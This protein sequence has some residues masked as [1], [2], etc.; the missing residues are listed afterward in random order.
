MKFRLSVLCA[1]ALLSASAAFAQSEAF[2]FVRID[3]NPRTAAMAGAGSA[4]VRDIAYAS[5]R[6][7]AVIPF[8][9]GTVD[10][11]L[12]WQRWAPESMSANHFNLSAGAK[13]GDAFGFSV[14][15]AYQAG[16]ACDSFRP[17]E[18]VV[19]AGG[20][21]RITDRLGFGVNFRYAGT[22]VA[23]GTDYAGFAADVQ[24]IYRALPG[25]YVSA[26]V[27]SAG[28]QVVS[29]SG[30][31]FSLPASFLVAASYRHGFGTDHALEGNLDQ[32]TFF[33]GNVTA[34]VGAEYGFRDLL[35]VRA[36]FHYGTDGAVLPTFATVGVGVQ[37][38]GFRLDFA[39]LTASEFLGNTLS[40][41]LGY[42]F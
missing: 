33:S 20:G 15:G 18:M 9:D 2:P 28:G 8:Y 4:S 26:G 29:S 37:Y 10:A 21:Y 12:N 11:G 35:F 3:R 1:A 27:V 34:A 23:K 14:G 32:N 7:A 38:A 19:N 31:K 41:G 5:F 16:E 6:N 42:G 13:L 30:D 39:Y 40:V 17:Y 25:L 22:T 24:V 36:G